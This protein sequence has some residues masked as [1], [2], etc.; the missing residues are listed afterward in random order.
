VL[1]QPV[2]AY[3]SAARDN[4]GEIVV[5]V[6]GGGVNGIISSVLRKLGRAED[7]SE[8]ADYYVLAWPSTCLD[9]D[10]Q[11]WVSRHLCSDSQE[12]KAACKNLY[13]RA[14]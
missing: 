7:G 12:I 10:V 3:L 5:V 9:V 8:Q 14:S 1:P 4:G 6:G 2:Y 13:R 11:A